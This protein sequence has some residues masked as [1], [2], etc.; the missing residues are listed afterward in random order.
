[1]QTLVSTELGKAAFERFFGIVGITAIALFCPP[2][3]FA[4]G[5]VQAIAGLEEAIEHRGIQRAMLGG[6]E[7]LSRAQV[8]A[9]L[10]G[11]AIGAA[12]AFVPAVPGVVKTVRGGV[13][14][15]AKGEARQAAGAAGRELAR[16]SAAH[17]AELA[18]KNLLE[19]YIKECLVG[20]VLTLAI[21]GAIG[22]ITDQVAKEVEVGAVPGVDDIPGVISR[23]FGGAV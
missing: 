4:I 19:A 7:I 9:E 8:E 2:A 1:M 15:V 16:R 21:E 18:A 22:R 6:D 17:F 20:Y 3:A 10:W 5:A 12:L 14:A 23:A 11:A 13:V